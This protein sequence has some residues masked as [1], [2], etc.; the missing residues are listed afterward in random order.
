[1][2]TQ[3]SHTIVSEDLAAIIDAD[4]PWERFEGKTVLVTGAGG[5]VG[6]YI[7]WTLLALN[8]RSDKPVKVIAS[9]RNASALAHKLGAHEHLRLVELPLTNVAPLELK[10]DFVIHAASPSRTSIHRDDPLGTIA[11]NVFGTQALLELAQRSR[12][13]GFLFVSSGAVYGQPELADGQRVHEDIAASY[14]HLN[15]VMSY[16]EGKRMGEFLCRAWAAQHGL[17]TTIARLG[18]T[19]G[20]GLEETD[21]RV[22]ADFAFRILRNEPIVIKSAGTAIRPFCYVTDAIVGL[23]TI[24]LRGGKGEAYNLVNVRNEFSMLELASALREEFSERNVHVEVLGQS[25]H[26][27]QKQILLSTDKLEAL[28]WEPKISIRE[29]FRRTIESY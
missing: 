29:G 4:L 7:V 19:Y 11:P 26:S 6:S 28:G 15:P 3:L 14:G 13:E 12:A 10:A 2:Q 18:H 22:F 23:F 16:A 17:Q 8:E 24:L 5:L 9:G 25:S 1:M 21:E 20:P 27:F